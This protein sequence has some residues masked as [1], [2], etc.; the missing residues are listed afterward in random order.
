M[1]WFGRIWSKIWVDQNQVTAAGK[2]RP[3]DPT[4]SPHAASDIGEK[5]VLETD[6]FHIVFSEKWASDKSENPDQYCFRH[7]ESDIDLV[8]SW[9]VADLPADKIKEGAEVLLSAQVDGLKNT[10]NPHKIVQSDDFITE[11]SWG[12]QASVIRVYEDAEVYRY[13]GMVSAKMI[14][15]MTFESKLRSGSSFEMELET[16]MASLR[17]SYDVWGQREIPQG[18]QIQ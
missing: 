15:N 5:L 1:N 8:I 13:F 6:L 18:S 7:E 11:Q 14:L 9:I 2:K 16:V 3:T 12:F 10:P 4:N 17:V